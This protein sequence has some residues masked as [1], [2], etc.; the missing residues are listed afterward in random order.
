MEKTIL[1][2]LILLCFGFALYTNHFGFNKDDKAV[3][4]EKGKQ[5]D[6]GDQ[7]ADRGSQYRTA[8]FYHNE[9]QK[10]IAEKSKS[11]LEE[12]GKFDHP[13]SN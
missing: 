10:E 13:I 1:M 3:S 9:R 8:I 2:M 4:K 11:E 6:S 5:G 12:S 7:F